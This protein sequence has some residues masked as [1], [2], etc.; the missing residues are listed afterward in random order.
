MGDFI[1]I[2]FDT[3]FDLL[4]VFL[5]WWLMKQAESKTLKQISEFQREFADD[6]R[7]TAFLRDGSPV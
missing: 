3:S 7:L 4:S 1:G 2:S 6:T 5:F